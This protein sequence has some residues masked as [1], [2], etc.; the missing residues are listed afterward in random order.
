MESVLDA[1][2][3]PDQTQE[4]L[5]THRVGRQATD[6]VTGLAVA[7]R[8]CGGDLQVDAQDQLDAGE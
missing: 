6:E 5:R 4:P 7:R 1:P 2:V 8:A 3:T